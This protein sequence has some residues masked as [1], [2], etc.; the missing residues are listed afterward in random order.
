VPERRVL[1]RR[2]EPWERTL[3][4]V[5][6]VVIALWLAILGVLLYAALT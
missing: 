6:A 2:I 1:G 5:S 4:R 3:I